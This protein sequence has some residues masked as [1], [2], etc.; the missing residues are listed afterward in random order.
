MT[1]TLL[2]TRTDLLSLSIGEIEAVED[3]VGLP[4]DEMFRAGKVRGRPLHAL[5]FVLARRTRPELTWEDVGAMIVRAEL[6]AE[7]DPTLPDSLAGEP[8]AS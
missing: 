7:P 3:A 8:G 2:V 4:F 6:A 1:E 5:A